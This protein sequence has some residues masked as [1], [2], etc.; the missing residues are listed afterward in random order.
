MF[1]LTEGSDLVTMLGKNGV[2]ATRTFSNDLPEIYDVLGIEAARS[3]L[4]SEL[5]STLSKQG[6]NRRHFQILADIMT[7]SPYRHKMVS[8]NRHGMRNTNT[9]VLA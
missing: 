9:G 8:I 1:I 6:V 2:D 5:N 7:A 4:I 3:L